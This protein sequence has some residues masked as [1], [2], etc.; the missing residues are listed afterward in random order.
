[1]EKFQQRTALLVLLLTAT[2]QLN[3]RRARCRPRLVEQIC[4][5]LFRVES[6][7][8]R[9]EEHRPRPDQVLDLATL[10]SP[11][12]TRSL[13]LSERHTSISQARVGSTMI[14]HAPH[15]LGVITTTTTATTAAAA[16]TTAVSSSEAHEL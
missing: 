12:P 2:N 7:F 4:P 6:I 1:M 9:N 10:R 13:H 11:L 15:L 8:T 14:T 16:A 5:F 3:P